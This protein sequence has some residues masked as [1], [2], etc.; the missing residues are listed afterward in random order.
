MDNAVV[1]TRSL[2][3]GSGRYDTVHDSNHEVWGR[4]RM[5]RWR[6]K[7]RRKD[8]DDTTAATPI[9]F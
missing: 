9:S 1:A 3:V 8:D 2:L 7:R 6:R 4:R 5:W